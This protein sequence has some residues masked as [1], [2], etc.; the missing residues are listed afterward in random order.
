MYDKKGNVAGFGDLAQYVLDKRIPLEIC[1]LSNVHTGA[2][3]KIEKHPFGIL[4]KEKFRVTINTDDRLMSNTTMTKEFMT[5][6]EYFNLNLEDVEK[7]TLNSMK[8]AFIPYKERLKYIYEI[9]KPGFQT[10][11]EQLLSFKSYPG[12][13][14]KTIHQ[15]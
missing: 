6:I 8:S 13:H 11:K 1:L 5:A 10:M 12:K 2:V 3:E 4:F 15:L 14:E 7:I 9:I